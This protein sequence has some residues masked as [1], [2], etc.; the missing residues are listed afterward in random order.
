MLRDTL[1]K[2]WGYDGFRPLQEDIINSVLS[3]CDTIG[4]MPTG[5]GKS[6][7]FQVPGMIKDG[8]TLVISP[9]I[10]LMKDQVDNLR[11]KHIKAVYF[12]SGMSGRETSIAWEKLVNGKAKFLY[13]SPERLQNE[14]FCL[15][16]K[17]LKISLI[18]VDEAHCISQ[19]GYDFRP[20]YMGI[21]KLRKLVGAV[22]FLA[23]TASATP[24]VVG[25]IC[26]NLE[27]QTPAIYAKSFSR[28]NIQYVV[29]HTDSK[30]N[31]ILHILS[32]VPGSAI[33]YVRSRK[34]TREIA[35]FLQ[36]QGVSAENYH[37]GL[38]F[39][40][41]E[42]RQNRWKNN[43][44]RVIVA[45]NA[46]G[47]GIDK[48]DV[49][50]VIHYDLPPSLE[51]YYQEAG[52]AGRD[53]KRAYAV[54]LSTK[55]DRSQLR[56]RLTESFPPKNTILKVYEHLCN[57]LNIVVGEGYNTLH[58]FNF[59]KFC[60]VFKLHNVVAK[61][62]LKILSSANYIDYIEETEICSR[63]MI[64]C[65][66]EEL[67]HIPETNIHTDLVLQMIL[68]LYPGLFSD[69]VFIS[70]YTIAKHL[71][72][73]EQEIYDALILL[74]KMGILHYVPRKRT[75]YI[76]M[77][78]SREELKYIEIGPKVY[79]ERRKILQHRVESMI[80]YAFDDSKCRVATMLGYFGEKINR[81]GTCDVCLE[82]S[83]LPRQIDSQ[84]LKDVLGYIVH[85][86]GTTLQLIKSNFSGDGKNIA[87]IVQFLCNEGYVT[88]K[89]GYY[90]PSN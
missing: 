78:T 71:S 9:L 29:R 8:I 27:M 72:I 46:F 43:E 28:P 19:W 53:G 12:H 6:I 35:D 86:Q 30:Q 70:E 3:G 75:P 24:A 15:E 82:K 34:R 73:T 32:K 80:S 84:V 76:Y 23:L 5:G 52:R 31:Q 89:E 61:S 54:L 64:V 37:A 88:Y 79:E 59:E 48:P 55:I 85:S 81:C 63:V 67:Y 44:T 49:R 68:R 87:E 83:E 22:P 40:E 77:P 18:V 26:R 33:V 74:T 58:E 60:E 66:K 17:S 2:Y 45:T 62:A 41:K 90:Y 39:E 65:T 4:L 38:I 14:R 16:L 36:Q 1:K 42:L 7:T 56:R 10:S 50:V 25:D 13:V 51:E 11:N 21:K 47:M 69:Y 20:S 57:F